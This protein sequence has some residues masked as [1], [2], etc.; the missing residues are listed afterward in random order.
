MKS[1]G[2]GSNPDRIGSYHILEVLDTGGM[3]SVY[4]ALDP[5]SST[6]VAIKVIP[7]EVVADDVLRM[8]FA[9]ECQVVRGLNHPHCVR[10][11]DFGLEGSMAYMV[12]EYVDGES[13]G[14][15][16]ERE[17]RLSEAEA[18]RLITQVGHA[19][20]YIHQRRVIHRDVKPDN[21]LLTADGQALLA[22]LGLAKNLDSDFQLTRTQSALGTPNFMAPEQFQ[23]AKRADARSDLYS[24]AATLYMLTTGELPF[25]ARS[26]R[27]VGQIYKK[28][29]AHELTPPRQLVPELSQSLE[30]E[31][32][33]ALRADR[34]ERHASVAEFLDCLAPQDPPDLG[35]TDPD[36]HAEA[37]TEER[38]PAE[39]D[40][41][42]HPLQRSPDRS[43]PG[44]V[45]NISRNGVCL[46]LGRRFEP[47]VLLRVKLEGKK[48]TRRQ[49][50]VARV[51]W[52]RQDAE[53]NWRLGCRF[54]QPLGESELSGLRQ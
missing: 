29:L 3:G 54:D 26:R 7:E 52:V 23:D 17:G 40:T 30:T 34:D 15:R 27:A 53:K 49:S 28:K 11:L 43:W 9:Q 36:V 1:T 38:F 13:L 4:K 2:P 51:M 22:D 47:G 42:C 6:V 10:V 5:V 31:V 50:V 39:C 24:L 32:L 48:G 41:S 14:R 44:K 37:R 16:L 33:K 12:L 8:R 21:I 45:V 35:G 20:H 46:K 18:V 25:R 19:L